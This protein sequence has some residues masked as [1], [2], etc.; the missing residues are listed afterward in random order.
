[1]LASAEMDP[2]SL[3]FRRSPP[4]HHRHSNGS[5]F[6][7]ETLTEHFMEPT[8][9]C[10][11]FA[12]YSPPHHTQ[13]IPMNSPFA[14][15]A[16]TMSHH[17][18]PLVHPVVANRHPSGHLQGSSSIFHLS[19]SPSPSSTSPS[20]AAES[21]SI[22]YEIILEAPTASAQK[23]DQFTLTY[24]NKGQHYAVAINDTLCRD[25]ELKTTISIAFHDHSH[26][27]IASNFWKYW[28]CQQSDTQTARAIDLDVA[29][30][31]GLID[32][33][34]D[35][36]DRV[37][38]T[39]NGRHGAKVLLK[40][41][42]LSTDFSRIKGVKGIPLRIAAETYPLDNEHQIERT[43]CKT[44]LFRDKG[45][46]RKNKDDT[47]HIERQLEK[48]RNKGGDSNPLW[49][50]YMPS[51]SYT[52]F[53]ETPPSPEITPSSLEEADFELPL[54]ESQCSIES[55]P[56]EEPPNPWCL[57]P[58]TPSSAELK[59]RFDEYINPDYSN[60]LDID[61]SY[62]PQ[63]RKRKAVL[64]FFVCFAPG[65]P[66]RAIYLEAFTQQD[67]VTK[68]CAKVDYVEPKQV[69][70]VVRCLISR[71]I[72]VQVDDAFVSSDIP[73]EQPMH[74]KYRLQDD[75]NYKMILHY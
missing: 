10:E 41:N 63:P 25:H 43:F 50:V 20:S 34:C 47:K 60:A 54:M 44:K 40:F 65:E 23:Q 13:S 73:E 1:M 21:S 27:Q 18:Y 3:R 69:A 12:S 59:R 9:A 32:P 15:D 36:F 19:P 58:T 38:F 56:S 37:S 28:I 71:P 24:L 51:L 8:M 48:L 6:K 62:V 31:S 53:Q 39:W 7:A 67:L 42:C 49:L 75:G 68:I 11:A 16:S 70:V 72:E 61:K 52:V 55:I 17:A 45:A 33:Q 74:V 2:A 26:R 22:R 4:R 57:Q 35:A 66:Y 30:S 14:I 5:M 46:E 29:G 64:S